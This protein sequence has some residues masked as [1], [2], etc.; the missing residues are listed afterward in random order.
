MADTFSAEKRSE[1]M[2]RIR[3]KNTQAELIVF[4][5]L[6]KN[7]VYFQKHYS[8]VSGKPDIALPRKKKAVFIDSEFWHGKDYDRVLKN[9]SP[10]DYWVKKIARNIERDKEVREALMQDGWKLLVVW[11]SDIKR[12]RTRDEKLEL[13]LSFLVAA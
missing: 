2:S 7:K 3:S 13:I 8:K 9:R 4:R 10:N 1:I 6:R 11:E 12:K 5:Y